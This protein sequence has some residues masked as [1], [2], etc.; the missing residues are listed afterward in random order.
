MAKPFWLVVSGHVLA[1]W[2]GNKVS[3]LV[4]KVHGHGYVVW[5][6]NAKGEPVVTN[7]PN[8][9]NCRLAGLPG[10]AGNVPS[11]HSHFFVTNKVQ[12]D[13][14]P[15]ATHAAIHPF[16]RPDTIDIVAGRIVPAGFLNGMPPDTV[17]KQKGGTYSLVDTDVWIYNTPV[18]EPPQ[19]IADQVSFPAFELDEAYVL[20]LIAAQFGTHH[21]HGKSDG[22]NKLL[23]HGGRETTYRF[24]D[25]VPEEIVFVHWGGYAGKIEELL[26]KKSERGGPMGSCDRGNTG[27]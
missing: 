7:L 26:T 1:D 25:E 3:I 23:K 16:R 8:E 18:E 19:L 2:G 17:Q 5:H 6:G 14:N 27:P 20:I 11:V 12:K 21:T 22:A 24:M 10:G 4:P 15:G 13:P 9:H